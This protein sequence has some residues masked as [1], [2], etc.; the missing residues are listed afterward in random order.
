[1]G[2]FVARFVKDFART[3]Q[4]WC[5]QPSATVLPE[6]Q[7]VPEKSR[8]AVT[9][10]EVTPADELFVNLDGT[11]LHHEDSHWTVEVCGVHSSESR[12]WVQVNL[13]SDELCGVTVCADRLE[14]GRVRSMLLDWLTTSSGVRDGVRVVSAAHA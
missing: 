13:C 9:G 11:V 3:Q 10:Y 6:S 7:A 1:M 14:A 4:E 2:A 8:S 12:H 5:L